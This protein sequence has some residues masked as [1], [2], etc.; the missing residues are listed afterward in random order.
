MGLK[1]LKEH[2]R[3]GHIIARYADKGV[4][5]GSNH[6]YDLIRVAET[7]EV[8]WKNA[9][10]ASSNADLC[11]YMQ[12]MSASS[13]TVARLLA[14]PDTFSA[15]LPVYTFKDGQVIEEFCENPGWPNLTHAGELMYNNTHFATRALA[16]TN[17]KNN[18]SC[19]IRS[20]SEQIQESEAK[21]KE[22]REYLFTLTKQ[23]T[24]LLES[25]PSAAE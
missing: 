15:A 6:I 1:S 9:S 12:E 2:F 20:V 21:L 7:G 14:E 23:L 24:A 16:A 18:L 17:A 10:I 11:R 3:I 13:E 4:C 22:H 19:D 8:K 25:Y 5:I